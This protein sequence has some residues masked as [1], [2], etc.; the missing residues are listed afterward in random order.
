M[1]SSVV[2]TMDCHIIRCYYFP[3]PLMSWTEPL[4][5][6]HHRCYY[7]HHRLVLRM[8]SLLE[9]RRLKQADYYLT[10]PRVMLHHY[11]VGVSL[12]EKPEVCYLMTVSQS[13]CL[14]WMMNFFVIWLAVRMNHS[15]FCVYDVCACVCTRLMDLISRQFAGQTD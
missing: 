13:R 11:L 2:L 9:T 7:Q 8:K 12:E 10:Q 5:V 1:F 4:V 15:C 6:H 14:F 3:N